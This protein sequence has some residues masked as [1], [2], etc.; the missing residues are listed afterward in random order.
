VA[1]AVLIVVCREA[2]DHTFN[3]SFYSTD[4]SGHTPNNKHSIESH[5]LETGGRQQ[6]GVVPERPESWHPED[7][8]EMDLGVGEMDADDVGRDT[9][10]VLPN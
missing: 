2:K 8:A 10:Y 1:S 7:D 6:E 9:E 5:Y 3:C 4:V